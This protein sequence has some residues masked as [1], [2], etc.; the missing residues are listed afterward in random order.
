MTLVELSTPRTEPDIVSNEMILLLWHEA[1]ARGVTSP[2]GVE[3]DLT[4]ASV[5][6]RWEVAS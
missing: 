6:F 1:Q 3:A 4:D 2:L 5:T